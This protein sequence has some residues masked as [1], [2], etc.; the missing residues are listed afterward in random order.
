LLSVIFANT[1][2]LALV[3]HV[4]MNAIHCIRIL[5]LLLVVLPLKLLYERCIKPFLPTTRTLRRQPSGKLSVEETQYDVEGKL[6]WHLGLLLISALSYLF[7]AIAILTDATQEEVYSKVSSKYVGDPTYQTRLFCQGSDFWWLCFCLCYLPYLLATLIL[8][9]LAGRD[10]GDT[11]SRAIAEAFGFVNTSTLHYL[12]NMQDAEECFAYQLRIQRSAPKLT[13]RYEVFHTELEGDGTLQTS[14]T[15]YRKRVV[16]ASGEKEIPFRSWCDCSGSLPDVRS[17]PQRLLRIKQTLRVDPFDA[18]AKEHIER[19]ALGFRRVADEA[20]SQANTLDPSVAFLLD[21]TIDEFKTYALAVDQPELGLPLLLRPVSYALCCVLLLA[22]PYEMWLEL[23]TFKCTWKVRKV[24][25]M[26]NL[27][28]QLIEQQGLGLVVPST[29]TSEYDPSVP[30]V[31]ATLVGDLKPA[32][33]D[34]VHALVETVETIVTT[35]TTITTTIT[36]GAP[37]APLALAEPI[38]VEGSHALKV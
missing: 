6:D 14:G 17:R 21:G 19:T 16:D 8:P 15:A 30:V 22:W 24:V 11:Q 31:E 34:D 32:S 13:L 33:F 9:Y 37:E 36:S 5:L 3:V 1:G 18:E 7:C 25:S 20:A 28:E 27:A 38:A 26:G 35:S 29:F 2:I 10:T 12:R 4:I 23:I